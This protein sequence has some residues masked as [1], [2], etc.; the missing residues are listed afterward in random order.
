MLSVVRIGHST[1]FC[2][3]EENLLHLIGLVLGFVFLCGGSVT[4]V[5]R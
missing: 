4:L 5:D 3:G 2:G 1:R